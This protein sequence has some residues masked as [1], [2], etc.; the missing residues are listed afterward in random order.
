M[1]RHHRLCFLLFFLSTSL[2]VIVKSN[3][4]CAAVLAP[5]LTPHL[6]LSFGRCG[7]SGGVVG[8]GQ[9]GL[10]GFSSV[11]FASPSSS[12]PVPTSCPRLPLRTRRT[13]GVSLCSVWYSAVWY[14]VMCYI[15][16]SRT[17]SFTLSMCV[18]YLLCVVYFS[19]VF[20]STRCSVV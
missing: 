12:A 9:G 13:C 11:S 3:R 2:R 10:G 4:I 1:G 18:Y 19:A 20:G 15:S 7:Y 14:G 8:V 17:L 5:I 6:Q 16:F